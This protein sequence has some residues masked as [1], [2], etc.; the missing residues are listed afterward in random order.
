MTVILNNQSLMITGKDIKNQSLQFNLNKLFS[1]FNHIIKKKT[2]R[3][4]QIKS[5]QFDKKWINDKL[6]YSR[7]I[8]IIKEHAHKYE[9]YDSNSVKAQYVN[10][11]SL[12]PLTQTKRKNDKKS[13][14]HAIIY[15]GALIKKSRKKKYLR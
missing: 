9:L 4:N 11:V 2:N 5:I 6:F 13:K 3:K 15:P 8:N 12:G 10:H 7:L 1:M 14:G